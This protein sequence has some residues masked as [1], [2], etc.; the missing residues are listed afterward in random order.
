MYLHK[1][2]VVMVAQVDLGGNQPVYPQIVIAFKN[3]TTGAYTALRNGMTILLGTAPGKDDYGRLRYK[4]MDDDYPTNVMHVS[5]FSQGTNDGEGV[6]VENSYLTVLEE[7][8]VWVKIPR[9]IGS[10][11]YKD[12]EEWANV[13][14]KYP[15]PVANAGAGVAGTI[16]ANGKLT[17]Q[18][19]MGNSFKWDA[20]V[21]A[22]GGYNSQLT[23]WLWEVGAGTITVGTTTSQSITVEFPAGFHYVYLKAYGETYPAPDAGV[24][25]IHVQSVP[26]F[27]RDPAADLS[28]T[29]FHI[30]GHQQNF[31]GQE[32]S[33]E[34]FTPLSRDDFPDGGLMMLWDDAI[35]Y[36][37]DL[38]YHMQF[39]GW[40]Q[41][42]SAAVRADETATL[43]S[44]RLTFV[45]VGRKL[46]LLPGFSQ[47]LKY[48]ANPTAWNQ[49]RFPS[50]FYYFWYILYWHSTALEVA[51]LRRESIVP[52]HMEFVVLSS[53]RANLHEQCESIA[54]KVTPDHHLTCSRQGILHVVADP[55]IQ[56]VGE[57]TSSD[58]DTWTDDD[59]SD[60][61]YGYQRPPKVQ[62]I[63]TMALIAGKNY[64][65]VGGVPTIPVVASRAPGEG[66]GQ[67]E[68]Y[69]E[70]GERITLS[71][72]QLNITEGHRYARLNARY[73]R[74]NITLP[75]ERVYE[76]Y[77][78]SLM[79]WVRLT[80]T[81]ANHPEREP[82]ASFSNQRGICH[83][84]TIQYDYTATGMT[85]SASFQWEME[86]AGRPAETEVLWPAVPDPALLA[87][88]ATNHA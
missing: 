88:R 49:T 10:V 37:P 22:A 59:W 82:L 62:Q 66:Q 6:L 63:R 3:V 73:G 47:E 64:V 71:Q 38:R 67:G 69:L 34:F 76:R 85:R 72:S 70:I 60:I 84:M 57:R 65:D 68:Q 7:Y 81:G 11:V 54:T 17:V 21:G 45:D 40:H 51:E 13:N 4:H 33:A 28:T 42:D 20:S 24:P 18:F 50:M 58:L 29:A 74:F 48:N 79:Q 83:E 43:H 23:N 9:M 55:M 2:K 77:D 46:Q 16:A 87:A 61:Q 36:A 52:L 86:T 31:V 1:P 25:N 26:V 41:S 32:I 19:F 30:A 15:P 14:A 78:L 39:V 75:W 80:I 12:G 53:D 5:R 27:A 56:A 8:R 44:T 35:A